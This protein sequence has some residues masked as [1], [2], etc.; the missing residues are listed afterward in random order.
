MVKVINITEYLSEIKK[1]S[2]DNEISRF[3][4]RGQ[5]D[6]EQDIE[7]SA[8][9]RIRISLNVTSILIDSFIKY[10]EKLVEIAKIKGYHRKENIELKDLELIA[11]LQHFSA[12]TFFIDFSRNPLI[13]LWFAINNNYEKDGAIYLLDINDSKRMSQV[14][15]NDIENNSISTFF[16]E[17]NLWYWEPSN[18]NLRIPKQHSIFVFGPPIIRKDFFKI[19]HV[20]KDFKKSILKDLDKIYDINDISLFS[21][22]PGFARANSANTIFHEWGA[23][24]YFTYGINFIQRKDYKKA[25]D[26]LTESIKL[27]ANDFMVY[28]ARGITYF[29]L[30]TVE[31]T[32]SLLDLGLRDFH[33]AIEINPEYCHAYIGRGMVFILLNNFEDAIKN[34]DKALELCPENANAYLQRGIAYRSMKRYEEAITDF[35]KAIELDP[36]KMEHYHSRG[37]TY[38]LMNQNT[39]SLDDLNFAIN[40]DPTNPQLYKSRALAKNRLGLQQEAQLD[41]EKAKKLSEK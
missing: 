40:L 20:D 25:I 32:E 1:I 16:S 3:I 17:S 28:S 33:K 31:K 2:E 30:F 34:F 7:S 37:L 22:L 11:E 21:D 18:F 14:T 39:L 15:F 9:R 27:N 29:N 23:D 26:Y 41:E 12:A 5:T 35:S 8:S 19:I 10:H 13:A 24:D 38:L 6:I 4:F 36:A